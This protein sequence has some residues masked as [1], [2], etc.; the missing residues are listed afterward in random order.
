MVSTKLDVIWQMS[1]KYRGKRRYSRA[2]HRRMEHRIM[3]KGRSISADRSA[4]KL[5]PRK[6]QQLVGAAAER[7]RD[8]AWYFAFSAAQD[9][10]RVLETP[11]EDMAESAS[12]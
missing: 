4:H 8:R 6:M 10:R 9:F 3:A 12:D 7:V 11:S 2:S 5:L 1:D